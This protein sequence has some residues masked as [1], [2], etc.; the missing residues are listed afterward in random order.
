LALER[1]GEAI[2]DPIAWLDSLDAEVVR[3]WDAY[4]RIEPFGNQWEQHASQMEVLEVILAKLIN[5]DLP[6]NRPDLRYTPRK[7]RDFMPAYY[8][9]GEPQRGATSG[10]KPIDQQLSDYAAALG[11]KS[12]NGNNYQ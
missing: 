12:N 6:S 9:D 10:A 3:L 11:L 2:D 4:S 5:R 7:R 8:D 1:G